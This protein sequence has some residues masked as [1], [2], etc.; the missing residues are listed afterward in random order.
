MLEQGNKS[1][2]YICRHNQPNIR[3]IL[4]KREFFI[5]KKKIRK[6]EYLFQKLCKK[7]KNIIF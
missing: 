1:T 2:I 7:Q 6:I 4:K 3:F 5:F